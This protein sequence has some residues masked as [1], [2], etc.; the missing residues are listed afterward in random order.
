MIPVNSMTNKFRKGILKTINI[1]HNIQRSVRL[2]HH[3]SYVSIIHV[4]V[5]R[6]F[7]VEIPVKQ[8]VQLFPVRS[9]HRVVFNVNVVRVKTVVKQLLK[10]QIPNIISKIDC[11]K[12]STKIDFKT[13]YTSATTPKS[14]SHYKV[15]S[16][17]AY[18][19]CTPAT[20]SKK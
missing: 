12:L 19:A 11:M 4:N 9:D 2:F 14:S 10:I 18:N 5:P 17:L 7:P 3:V 20:T 6:I 1:A 16:K 15:P 13:A 8:H